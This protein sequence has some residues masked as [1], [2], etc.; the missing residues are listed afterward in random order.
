MGAASMEIGTEAHKRL[1]CGEFTATHRPFEPEE[2][3]WPNLDEAELARLQAVPFWQEVFHTE[4]RAGAIV[5][6][7]ALTINDPAIREAVD[8]QGYEEA[9]HARL[10]R[11]LIDRYQVNATELPLEELPKDIHT[12]FLDFGYGECIDAFLGF[13]MFKIA[14]Q[15]GFLPEALFQ[16]L[17]LLMYEETRH[18][19]FFVNWMAY[20]E[21]RRGRG[22]KPLRALTSAWYYSRVL[23]RLL[24]TLRQGMR[25]KGDGRD[26]LPT[27]MQGLLGDFSVRTL[28]GECL[29]ENE[30]RMSAFDPRLLKPQ[31]LPFLGRAAAVVLRIPRRT[32]RYS[33]DR[34]AQLTRQ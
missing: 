18:I 19:V 13:G 6:Q 26:F 21:A 8:L 14:R 12:A 20:Q 22:A 11:H 10:I 34:A 28:V 24:G 29:R 16:V 9:R 1:F 32:T 31:L 4:R 25:D 3:P 5:G 7:F 23:R 33:G 17:D 30:R 27:E 2:L 15:A